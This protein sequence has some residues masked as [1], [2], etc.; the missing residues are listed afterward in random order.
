MLV[1]LAPA[2][3]RRPRQILVG[4]CVITE[5]PIE[6]LQSPGSR[7]EAA[8][9]RSL[10]V[11]VSFQ[12]RRQCRRKQRSG[13]HGRTRLPALPL[14][15]TASETPRK[16]PVAKRRYMEVLSA[17]RCPRMSPMVLRGVLLFSRCTASE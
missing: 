12:Q 1:R 15:G 9:Q 3:K 13:G 16:S 2:M 5:K 4:A 8:S 10:Q 17:V 6:R 14:R 11:D 7:R